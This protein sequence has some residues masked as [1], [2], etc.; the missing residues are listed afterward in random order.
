MTRR[1]RRRPRL[2]DVTDTA[3]MTVIADTIRRRLRHREITRHPRA[4]NHFGK[5]KI[6]SLRRGDFFT[7][8]VNYNRVQVFEM[9][10]R[11]GLLIAAEILLDIGTRACADDLVI[12]ARQT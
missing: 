12:L 3:D 2:R 4:D 6:P 9:A 1:P 5:I 8:T 10:E 7:R 11:V